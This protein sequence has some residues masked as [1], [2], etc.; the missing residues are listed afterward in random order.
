[1]STSDAL[2]NEAGG[3]P[4]TADERKAARNYAW[5]YFALHADQRMKLF[6]FFLT[7]CGLI[8]A[9]FPAV[10]KMAPGTK[11]VAIL[12]SFLV[13]SAFVF[14]KLDE[15]TRQLLKN[16]EAALKFLDQHWSPSADSGMPNYLRL[17]ERDDYR[18]HEAKKN[19]WSKIGVPITYTD[20]F[21]LVFLMAG[22]VGFLLAAW[23]WITI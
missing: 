23:A 13:L 12:P 21:R 2:M 9:A 6:N 22:S 14:W 1:M 17:F 11:L 18:K 20:N 19:W 3:M 16:A 8:L 15:R 7:L 4:M 5:G 10:T